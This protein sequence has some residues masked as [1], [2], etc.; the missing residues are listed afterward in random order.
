MTPY[1]QVKPRPRG[2]NLGTTSSSDTAPRSRRLRVPIRILLGIIA[3]AAIATAVWFAMRLRD[4][5]ARLQPSHR[6][7]LARLSAFDHA[8]YRTQARRDDLRSLRLLAQLERTARTDPSPSNIH[9]LGLGQL[10][11][12]R[13]DD[14]IKTLTRAAKA[15]PQDAAILS[16]L[17]AAQLAI[18]TPFAAGESA[19]L[20]LEA[21]KQSLPAMFNW[22]MSMD[23][24]AATPAAIKAWERY[25]AADAASE[26]SK[27][28]RER[29]ARLKQPAFDWTADQKLLKPTVDQATLERLVKR[30]PQRVRTWV[31]E[32]L[33]PRW[34]EGKR[35]E[36]LALATR[37]A[38]LRAPHDPYLLDIVRAATAPGFDE[39][40]RVYVRARKLSR[41]QK[42]DEA[43]PFFDQAIAQMRAAA[44]PMALTA[45][46]FAASN[47]MGQGDGDRALLLLTTLPDT[48]KYPSM[49]A[50]ALW[51]RALTEYRMNEP[52]DSLRCVRE[53]YALSLKSGETEHQAALAGL[54]AGGL[55]RVSD[56]AEA[57]R[58]SLTALRATAAINATPQYRHN[59]YTEAVRAAKLLRQTH[60]QLAFTECSLA[61]AHEMKMPGAIADQ[62]VNRAEAR[63]ALG[64]RAGAL[65]D[66]SE[67]RRLVTN[68]AT[69]GL[70]DLTLAAADYVTA[71]VDKERNPANALAALNSAR[72]RWHR[73]KW[74]WYAAA[75]SL[76][77]GD[78]QRA[79]G[80]RRAAE[81][82]YLA[83][84][85]GME[86]ARTTATDRQMRTSYF[87]RAENLF[88]R[89]ITLLLEEQRT[90]DALSIAERKRARTLLDQASTNE[91]TTAK[92][93]D[94]AGL[95]ASLDPS[96]RVIEFTTA[97]DHVFAWLVSGDAIVSSRTTATTPEIERH[98]E[99]LR[100]AMA[101]A[102]EATTRTEAAWLYTQLF[103]AFGPR[104]DDAKTVIIV[105]DGALFNIP[106]GALVAPGGRYLVEQC[107]VSIS[108]SASVWVNTHHATARGSVLAVAQPSPRD[109]TPLPRAADDARSMRSLYSDAIVLIGDAVE[110]ADFLRRSAAARLVAFSGHATPRAL[111]FQ[112][113]RDGHDFLGADE[114]ASHRLASK[115]TVIL[116]ACSTGQGTLR[117]VEGI[118]SIATAFLAAGARSVVA[119]LWDIEDEPSSAM[120]LAINKA[121]AA[122]QSPAAAVRTAQLAMLRD[123]SATYRR[124]A[125]WAGVFVVGAN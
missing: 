123:P 29:L 71:V 85:E 66:L 117:R 101:S 15:A 77:M 51:V 1:T 42:K 4:P 8:P 105:P 48:S 5:L 79:R 59:S 116:A 109:F 36:D 125:N 78:I 40:M 92:P 33:L 108:P 87:E 16:D 38:Q 52:V 88:D 73:R 23:S 56:E 28:A 63:N 74:S 32:D 110:T 13:T 54:I 75:A 82:E 10:L 49:S 60:V 94:A 84:I 69:P 112:S 43:A 124:P 44:S 30:Y 119:T 120:F 99:A 39:A 58:A 111:V 26:W 3:I 17:S 14:A 89:L 41:A 46:I 57:Q 70:R 24:L 121:L 98:I 80:D 25:L 114:V 97:S 115:P 83:G 47:A 93:L 106:F 12:G 72:D 76:E 122:G 90:A 9:R 118:D 27:E 65:R 67:A 104:L 7:T 61:A 19:A 100:N 11:V 96:T 113:G 53:A 22:A 6:A 50:E 55:E 102:N 91:T 35:P 45:T 64:D 62:L 103:G 86:Q 95:Q 68:E 107:E 20:A 21:D 2:H 34:V 31:Q 18:D 37:I 81:A